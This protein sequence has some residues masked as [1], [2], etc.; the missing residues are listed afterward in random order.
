MTCLPL[1]P[2]EAPAFKYSCNDYE[3]KNN[4]Q[5]NTAINISK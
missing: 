4:F 3:D 2:L 5:N 1:G